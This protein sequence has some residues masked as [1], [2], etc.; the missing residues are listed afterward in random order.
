MGKL[1]L[2]Y[3]QGKTLLLSVDKNEKSSQKNLSDRKSKTKVE[4]EIA[5]DHINQLAKS[6]L[7]LQKLSQIIN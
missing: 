7:R 3:P 4:N 1:Y 6:W 2:L 5:L